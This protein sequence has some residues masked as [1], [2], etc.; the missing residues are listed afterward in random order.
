MSAGRSDLIDIS[1]VLVHE[2]ERAVL[3]DHGGA[4]TVWLPKSA[5]EIERDAG[6]RTWTVT[7]PERLAAEKGLL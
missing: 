5:V 6:G 1:V 7:L 2:T 3:V 4:E